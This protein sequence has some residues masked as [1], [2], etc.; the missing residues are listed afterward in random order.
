MN[1]T[2]WLHSLGLERYGQA[3]RENEVN[4]SALL[5]LTTEDLKELRVI[6]VGHRRVLLDATADPRGETSA[7]HSCAYDEAR[8]SAN[9]T[10]CGESFGD[11]SVSRRGSV[12]VAFIPV[13]H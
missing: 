12:G 10:R 13:I 8:G 5:K 9:R 6:A 3:S 7:T 11:S 4:E 1:I 2:A